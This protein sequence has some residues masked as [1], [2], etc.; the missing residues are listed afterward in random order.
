MRRGGQVTGKT[1]SWSLAYRRQCRPQPHPYRATRVPSAYPASG[2][3]APAILKGTIV[4]DTTAISTDQYLKATQAAK[5]LSMSTATLARW[6]MHGLGPD[7]IKI[8]AT[9]VRYSR[10]AIERWLAERL[11][12]STSD[13]AAARRYSA[14][15]RAER[16]SIQLR[17]A[18]GRLLAP[19]AR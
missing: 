17:D 16:A 14:L 2:M 13:D 11:T 18:K 10:A 4:S 1:S 7:Y 6:R 9:V 5:F 15:D 3:R 8:S 19:E 12:T